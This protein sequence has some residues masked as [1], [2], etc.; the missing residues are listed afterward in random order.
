MNQLIA[1]IFLKL[2][3]IGLLPQP[4]VLDRGIAPHPTL[5]GVTRAGSFLFPC[6]F[7]QGDIRVDLY[8]LRPHLLPKRR[9]KKTG[10]LFRVKLLK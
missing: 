10:N 1:G 2:G 5:D 6:D 8:I 9:E 4:Q 3:V 7:C